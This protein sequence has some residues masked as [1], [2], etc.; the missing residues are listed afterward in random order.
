MAYYRAKGHFPATLDGRAYRLVAEDRKFWCKVAA[1]QWERDTFRFLDR[2]LRD[3]SVYLDI[4]AWIGP[5]VLF[6][7]ARC[8]MVYCVEP[9]PIAYQRLLANLRM[10]GVANVRSFHGALAARGGAV[11]IAS[12]GGFGRSVTRVEVRAPSGVRGDH[13]T[14]LAMD[15]RALLDLWG[16]ARIDV[17]KIDI[18][19]AEFDLMPS[20]MELTTRIKPHIHLSLHAP[21][22]P[23]SER[24]DKLAAV[25]ALAERYAHCYD[26]RLAEIQPH[27]ILDA[28]LRFEEKPRSVVLT[29]E[30]LSKP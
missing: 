23:R 29:D 1:G 22:F 15:L 17:L 5:T 19:G 28:R 18:E 6:A 9:D 2:C 27:E 3:D 16:I 24:R 26:Q 30:V 12:E 25:V 13:A 10:N 8:R 14:V 11:R 20:L 4:G 21:F 7:A